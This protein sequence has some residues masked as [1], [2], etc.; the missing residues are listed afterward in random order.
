MTS[1]HSR[2]SD[3]DMEILNSYPIH[4]GVALFP[5]FQALDVF[6]P[7]DVL[8]MV[9]NTKPL[10]L[11]ILAATLDPVST[12][13]RNDTHMLGPHIGQSIVPTHTFDDPPINIEVLLVP[14]G[15]GTRDPNTTQVVV[16]FIQDYYPKLDYLLTVCTGSALAAQAGVLDGHKATTNKRSYE[17]VRD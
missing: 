10:Q 11:S 8:N 5:G 1:N 7:M 15:R 6:G 13:L 2:P 3:S 14:G 17:W 12:M 4:Y 9:S 16:D